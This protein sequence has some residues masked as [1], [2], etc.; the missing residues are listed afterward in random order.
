G[1]DA[2]A[3]ALARRFEEASGI[4]SLDVFGRSR[5]VD[6]SQ[7]RPRG[8]YADHPPLAR[9]FRAAMFLSRFELNLVSRSSPGR[10]DTSVPDPGETAREELGA[11]ALA[12]LAARAGVDQEIAAVDR[13]WRVLAGAR[14]DVGLA[15]LGELRVKAGIASLSEPDAAEQL[16]RAI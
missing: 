10:A 14:E 12:E 5:R 1:V 2:E 7:Y 16:R 15:D 11:L 13:A 6:F 8:R 3:H 9:Y 4:G